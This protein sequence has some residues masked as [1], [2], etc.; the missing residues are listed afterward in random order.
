MERNVVFLRI[1]FLDIMFFCKFYGYVVENYVRNIIEY[2]DDLFDKLILFI[3]VFWK[4]VNGLDSNVVKK[5]I[6][7]IMILLG[8]ILKLLGLVFLM[9]GIVGVIVFVLIV[10]FKIIFSLINFKIV[11]C[12]IIKVYYFNW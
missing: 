5:V 6:V 8:S 7:I 11:L 3:D 10:F 12:L 9:V 4:V 1:K 2:L